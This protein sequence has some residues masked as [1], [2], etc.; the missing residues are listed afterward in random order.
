MMW[1]MLSCR[2]ENLVLAKLGGP[3]RWVAQSGV[4]YVTKYRATTIVY[5]RTAGWCITRTPAVAEASLTVRLVFLSILYKSKN[6]DRTRQ[7]MTSRRTTQWYHSI[8]NPYNRPSI[9]RKFLFPGSASRADAKHPKI[10]S[11]TNRQPMSPCPSSG[12]ERDR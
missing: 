12:H 2:V 5:G 3:V 10:P 8:S 11:P 6:R 7:G 9:S 1:S 4:E